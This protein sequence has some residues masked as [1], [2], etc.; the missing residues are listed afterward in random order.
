[1]YFRKAK[2]QFRAGFAGRAS[3]EGFVAENLCASTVE[4]DHDPDFLVSATAYSH[5]DF[6]IARLTSQGGRDR[7]I[8]GAAEISRDAGRSD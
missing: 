2:D 3:Y 6:T 4:I 7:M 1:M 5:A 8:R